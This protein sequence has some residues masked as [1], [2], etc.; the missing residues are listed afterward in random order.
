MKKKLF[1]IIPIV[2]AVLVFV[3][4]YLYYN[5]ADKETSLNV[6]EKRWLEENADTVVDFEIV[7]NFPLYGMNGEGVLFQFL[8]DFEEN[9]GLE[10][11]RIPY[12]K[13]SEPTTT[14][15]RIRILNNEDALSNNDL[16]VFEDGY[17]MIGKTYQ[18]ISKISD[19]KDIT[20]GVFTD[21]IAELSYYL[22]SGSDLSYKTYNTIDELYTALDNEEVNM[23]IVPNIMYLD[24]FIGQDGYSINYYFTEMSKKIVLTLSDEDGQLNDIMRKYYTNWK[25]NSYV[26]EYNEAYFDYY[27]LKNNINDK[28]RADLISKNYVYG[29]V[30]NAPYDVTI[31]D[32]TYGI[33]SEYLHRMERLTNIDFTYQRYDNVDELQKAVEKGEVDVYFDYYNLTNDN[34]LTTLSTFIEDY[35]V[36]GKVKDSHIVSSLE[37]LKGQKIAMLEKNALYDFFS[38]N[39]RS[40]ITTFSNLKDLASK[41]ENNVIVVDREVY[42]YYRTSRFSDYEVLYIDTMMNDYKFMV[43]KENQTFYDLF[44]YIINTNSYYRY[45]NSGLESLNLSLFEKVSFQQLYFVILAIVLLP[46]L[47]LGVLYLIFK[48]KK[49]IKEVRKEDR[50][51]YTDMLTSLKNRNYLNLNMQKWEECNVFP[52]AIVIIDLNNVKYV[53]DNYGHEA[54]DDLIVK[55][56]SILVNTQLE[57]SEIIRTDGN[58]FLIY[59]MGYSE[60]QVTTYTKK[61]SKELKELPHEFG[62]S[63][64][65]SMINDEIKTIDDAINEATLEMRTQKEEYK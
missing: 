52:Q 46:L 64:G 26:E 6:R 14:N 43:K 4:V 30:E 17:V 42:N 36:L 33:A 15:Y 56:A 44:N 24:K 12:L 27:V 2:I 18:R 57:N 22:K 58:E 59:L 60:Q 25:S 45:R 37:S 13:E 11:N 19:L 55:A 31:G 8:D 20:F 35:V 16:L 28:S 48:R 7:N 61:L 29:Y 54:G 63:I 40:T 21:D 51:K 3:G 1:I 23:I 39:G 47:L 62:A 65:F 38:N 32:K 41:A 49:K 53:N 10:F 5:M 9:V 34:Y 50:R